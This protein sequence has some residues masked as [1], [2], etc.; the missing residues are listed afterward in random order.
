MNLQN[1][2]QGWTTGRILYSPTEFCNF[3]QCAMMTLIYVCVC[4]CA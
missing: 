4:V 2:F 1:N 3:T